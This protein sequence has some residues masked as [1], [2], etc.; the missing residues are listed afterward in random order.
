MSLP[1]DWD[2]HGASELDDAI[3]D[4]LLEGRVSVDEAPPGYEDVA[5]LIAV[6][7]Q[8]LEA[9]EPLSEPPTVSAIVQLLNRRPDTAPTNSA[10]GPRSGAKR[11]PA[12]VAAGILLFAGT[13]AA[14]SGH[15][16]TTLQAAAHQVAAKLGISIPNPTYSVSRIDPGTEHNVIA[17]GGNGLLPLCDLRGPPFA[18]RP[19]QPTTPDHQVV[20]PPPHDHRR[21]VPPHGIADGVMSISS[22]VSVDATAESS[23]SSAAFPQHAAGAVSSGSASKP[24]T[25]DPV[26]D[27]VA[28]SRATNGHTSATTR[29]SQ[30]RTRGSARGSGNKTG[31]RD[32]RGHGA[33][34]ATPSVPSG[35]KPSPPPPVAPRGSNPQ[36]RPDSS[37]RVPSAGGSSSVAKTGSPADRG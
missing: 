37:S 31:R 36:P 25:N 27:H 29:G 1:P 8:G 33:A 32:T 30:A 14:A 12:A 24:A 5:Q 7:R 11:T 6:I 15:L 22:S 2:A 13:A 16:P 23:S 4:S 19:S 10:R 20:T 21:P 34:R 28:V 17:A 18:W 3:S 26:H 35:P 9:E